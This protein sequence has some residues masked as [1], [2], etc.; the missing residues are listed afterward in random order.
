MLRGFLRRGPLLSD[1]IRQRRYQVASQFIAPTSLLDVGCGQAYLADRLPDL[2]RYVG[3]DVHPLFLDQAAA[4]Y[5]RHQF[6]QINVEHDRLPAALDGQT[7]ATITLFALLEHLANAQHI[8]A[9]LSGYLAPGGRIIATTPTPW[10]HRVHSAGAQ[11]G[12]FY[13]EAADDHKSIFNRSSLAALFAGAGL[14]V[15]HY[16]RFELGCNQVIVA[17]RAA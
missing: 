6:Y 7:F 8:L 14:Q 15:Q 9:L 3:I 16:A 5:P 11:L 12:L 13:R 1:Y 17:G 4:R 10:G 2:E